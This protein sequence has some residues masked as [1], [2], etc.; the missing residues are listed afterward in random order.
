MRFQMHFDL[1]RQASNIQGGRAVM[2][3]RAASMAAPTHKMVVCLL[4][5]VF[6]HLA[7][8]PTRAAETAVVAG[9]D[10]PSE[11]ESQCHGTKIMIASDADAAQK[12]ALLVDAMEAAWLRSGSGCRA[13]PFFIDFLASVLCIPRAWPERP[14]NS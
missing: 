7:P 1:V 13:L 5:A 10:A 12:V 8:G 4:A 14:G 6:L 2:R 11:S 3:N 9:Q